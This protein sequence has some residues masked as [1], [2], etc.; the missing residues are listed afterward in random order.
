[1]PS[2][3]LLQPFFLLLQNIVS[4]TAFFLYYQ[5][6]NY[7]HSSI[8]TVNV[9]RYKKNGEAKT[10]EIEWGSKN[11]GNRGYLVVLLRGGK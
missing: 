9:G 10:V 3:V 8:Y 7:R 1:M 5:D 11:R 2:A 6:D 4:Q